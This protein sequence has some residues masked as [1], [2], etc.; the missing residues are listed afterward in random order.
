[1]RRAILTSVFILGFVAGATIARAETICGDFTLAPNTMTGLLGSSFW[2]Y[3]AFST[4]DMSNSPL[5]S[6]VY[7][8]VYTNGSLYLYLYQVNNT[9]TVG[10]N[11]AAEM[12]TL[13]MVKG[14]IATDGLGYLTETPSNFLGGT[15]QMAEDT[16][17]VDA[18]LLSGMEISFYYGKKNRDEISAGEHTAVL[19]LLSSSAPGAISGSVID[20]KTATGTVYGPVPEPGMLALL[21]AGLIGLLVYAW[22]TRLIDS[23]TM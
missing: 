12:F 11:S 7:S 6:E 8:Q 20:S 18:S 1:M 15:Q 10:V 4:T 22:K 13:G 23:L 14:T 17:F 16:A 9:G 21:A 2:N 19:Y 3:N 5:K